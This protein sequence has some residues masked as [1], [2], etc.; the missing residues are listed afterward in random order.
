[1]EAAS[2]GVGSAMS[3]LCRRVDCEIIFCEGRRKEEE[4]LRRRVVLWRRRSDRHQQGCEAG[5]ILG[6]DHPTRNQMQI[7]R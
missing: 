2:G 1:M 6:V 7:H 5:L 4:M 3:D